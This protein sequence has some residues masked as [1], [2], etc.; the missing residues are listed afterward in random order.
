MLSLKSDVVKNFSLHKR[1]VKKI[2][3][4]LFKSGKTE[5][6]RKCPVCSASAAYS[7]HR[8]SV[9][10][11]HYHQ[12]CDCG[13]CFVINRPLK[14]TLDKFYKNNRSYFSTYT[15]RRT[16]RARMEKVVLPK[17]QWL[18]GLFSTL[19][20]RA[21]RSVLDVGAGGGH[22][23]HACRKLKIKANGIEP[24]EAA[25]KF[26][27]TNFGIELKKDDF[28]NLEKTDADI[29]TF[30]GVI[31][32]VPLP[33]DFLRKAHRLLRGK[34]TLV[35]V[36]VPR[37]DS[38]STLLQNSF[39]QSIIRHLDPLG[40]INCFTDT[41]LCRSFEMA[42]IEPVAAWYFG[43]DSYEILVQVLDMLKIDHLTPDLGKKIMLLQ[44]IIDKKRLSDTLVLVGRK[45][46][47]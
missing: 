41:S 5:R 24:S 44:E 13:H 36:E 20:G 7:E 14:S 17:A 30:W 10:G 37:W 23:V 3:T 4:H 19:Y 28:M 47:D 18:T 29:I 34:D 46:H 35:V 39:P 6:I 8:L 27:A 42:N 22:F 45:K 25:R 1:S 33:V 32:H 31:E 2:R 11:A 15:D 40:H 16:L 26:C 9:Y 21:P 38:V 12:C 43:M